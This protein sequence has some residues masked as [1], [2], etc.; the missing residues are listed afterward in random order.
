[1]IK[2]LLTIIIVTFK[3]GSLVFDTIDSAL[4]Q[5]YPNIQLIVA[6]DG[7]KDF[8]KERVS[9]YITKYAGTNLVEALILHPDHNSGTVKNI[10]TAIEKAKGEFIKIIAGD[11]AF[12]SN[13]IASKQ[14]Y[15][16][17]KN[18]DKMLV[19]G[20]CIE[21]DSELVELSNNTCRSKDKQSIMTKSR[22][23]MLRYFCKKDQS[24]LATQA[25]CFRNTFFEEYGMYDERFKLVEDLPMGVRIITKDIPFGYQD[26]PSVKHRGAIGVSTSTN[27]FDEKKLLYYQDLYNYFDLV[28]YPLRNTIGNGFVLMRRALLSFRIQYTE[29]LNEDKGGQKRLVLIIKNIV[30]IMYFFFSRFSRFITYILHS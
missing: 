25:I 20:N 10:N 3:H 28:L 30:P 26:V 15:Y 1:M 5:D 17:K 12:A 2:D 27:P 8:D 21:C 13:E 4:S 16:L 18:T 14:I 6:E 19:F 11:D 24:F 7:E 9:N 22:N 23:E 29:A